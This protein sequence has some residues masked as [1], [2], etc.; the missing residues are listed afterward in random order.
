[1]CTRTQISVSGAKTQKKTSPFGI[2]ATKNRFAFENKIASFH[3]G[4]HINSPR[5]D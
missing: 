3:F 5:Y 4:L 2:L 1:M